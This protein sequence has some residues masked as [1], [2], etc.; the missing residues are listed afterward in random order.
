MKL[1]KCCSIYMNDILILESEYYSQISI[2]SY[3]DVGNVYFNYDDNID[4]S[5][6]TIL[7]V[8]L[9]YVIDKKFLLKFTKLKVIVS[10][11][12]ALTHIDVECCD[13]MNIKVYSLQNCKELIESVT[14]TSELTIGLIISLLRY[15]VKSHNSVITDNLWNR[16]IFRSR[17]LSRM[18]L[19]IIGIGRIGG[20]VAKYA[21][22]F[23][24]SISAYDPY[25]TDSRF[26]KLQVAKSSLESI[27]SDSDI[28]TI[29][30]NL[31]SDN[32]NLISYDEIKLMKPG[33]LLIN[34]AR[35]QLMDEQA[36]CEGIVSN[37]I[38]GI[39]V[40]VLESEHK[41]IHWSNS[42]FVNL[43]RN[44]MNVLITPHIGGCTTD[45]MHITEDHMSKL[46]I[47]KIKSGE[48]YG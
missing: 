23:G 36:V 20:H 21:K 34:T 16:D 45:A 3:K 10:P 4:Y 12:T 43:A 8:R 6:I 35:G 30:A 25:Q 39:A 26:E 32:F 28:I 19:G 27:L 29:H 7:V 42:P 18:K 15:I 47:S 2:D 5:E 38:G 41:D 31:R 46:I 9:N 22:S 33:V 11:T 1:R 44:G 24:M 37:K 40:D 13:L 14:S 48:I 17:Q